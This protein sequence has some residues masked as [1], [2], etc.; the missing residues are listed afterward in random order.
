KEVSSTASNGGA[1]IHITSAPKSMNVDKVS[2]QRTETLVM[3]EELID[4]VKDKDKDKDKDND[5][6][7]K[8]SPQNDKD[9]AFANPSQSS[10]P[11]PNQKQ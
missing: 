3:D 6:K 2:L 11:K 9:K 7:R 4:S 8:V 10:S 1:T 5:I